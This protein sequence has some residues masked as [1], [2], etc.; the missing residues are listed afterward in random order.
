M[1]GWSHKPI[2]TLVVAAILLGGC[3]K[4][5]RAG[6]DSV[7]RI[8]QR[9]EPG[10]ID[11]ATANLPDEVFIIQALSEGLVTP[12]PDGGQPIAAAAESWT[13]SADGL[14]YTFHLRNNGTWSNGEPVTAGDFVA[15]YQRVLN[16]A[17]AAPKASL[18]FMV[19]GAEAYLNGQLRDFAQ[20]G[21]RAVDDLTLEVTLAHP[22][23][24]FLAYVA[25]AP[26]TPVNPRVVAKLG[27]LWT[28]PGN[29]IGNGPYNLKEWKPNQHII[30]E[31]RVDYWDA[32]N[33]KI[34]EIRFLAYDNGD[35][36]ER[37]FRA[38][39]LDV[40]MS[41][42][43]TKISGYAA[44]TPSP[45]RQIPLHETRFLAF[46]TQRAPLNDVRV[47]RAL[48]LALDRESIVKHVLH[49]GQR[50]AYSFVPVG[51]GG[52]HPLSILTENADE[53]RALL[54]AAGY[55]GGKGFPSLELAGWT[56]TPVLEAVQAMWKQH[57]GITVQIGSRDAKV[58]VASLEKGDYDIGFITAIPD[59]ADAADILHDLRTGGTS[60]YSQWGNREYDA[61]LDG[62]DRM[63]NAKD[64]DAALGKAEALLIEQCPIAPL[65]FNTKN[66]LQ[67]PAVQ[68]WQEDALWNRF[69]KGVSL[70]QP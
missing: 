58:H 55:P 3:S 27:R 48:T 9:N 7:L 25:S 18:L 37:A 19:R 38:G 39:Q 17:T 1:S 26:W 47:R 6:P 21:F 29:F 30:V 68:H 44:Q 32:A 54:A 13:L 24:Q 10:D 56:Q 49:G 12:A 53:A 4:P 41:V 59:V 33:V 23:P 50:A 70:R 35:A 5:D 60:N 11:P 66:I 45:L 61:L 65:Y 67:R 8:S 34:E 15:S 36:E 42:P 57:L 22:A 31:R 2:R 46:N 20:V 64:R 63:T 43:F 28:R 14:V 52:F 62:A 40:T 16:P 69:Y 51:L